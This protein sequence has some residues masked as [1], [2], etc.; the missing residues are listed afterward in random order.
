MAKMNTCVA[1]VIAAGIA[2][3]AQAVTV[4][5]VSGTGVEK[6]KV[7]VEVEGSAAFKKTLERNLFL[8]GAFKLATPKHAS[9]RV[10]GQVGGRIVAQGRG[11]QLALP[12]RAADDK[13]ARTEARMLADKMCEA[14][15]NQK[16][17]ASDKIVFVCK[18]GRVEE[19]CTGYADGYDVRQLTNARRATVGPRW[20]DANTIFYT[21]YH[22]NAPQIFEISAEGGRSRMAWGFGGLTTGAT[23][24]PDGRTA[25]IILSKPFGN[26][27]LCTIDTAR[28]TWN[29]L[30]TTR[31]GSEGQPAWS[32]DGKKIVYV[33]DESRRQHLY[34][35]DVNGKG[36]RRLTSSGRQNVDP[37]WGPDGRIAYASKRDKGF[38]IAVI[39]PA[40]GD[41][42]A[43]LVT[44]PGAWEHPSWAR[45][46]RHLVAERD[47]ALFL[48]DTLENGDKPVKLFSLQGKCTMPS[49]QR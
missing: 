14:Y 13:A 7:S 38:Q 41:K 6:T 1:A 8:S 21:G 25:A 20:K 17:F 10:T 33:S 5:D 24:S 31:A 29:R 9:I 44:E 23:M 3:A 18:N 16:G 37:D 2:V 22:N 19:L 36:K 48:I 45:D 30:T 34:M 49:W 26:P 32:P 40:E 11:K 35:I 27:E 15:A 43:S 46:R 12:S 47:G 28:K 39:S 4:V 42:A